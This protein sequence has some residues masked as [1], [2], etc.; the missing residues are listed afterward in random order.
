MVARIW[1]LLEKLELVSAVDAPPVAPNSATT[2]LPLPSVPCTQP[3]TPASEAAQPVVRLARIGETGAAKGRP[4]SVAAPVEE[5]LAVS[6]SRQVAVQ[7]RP[8]LVYLPPL[9]AP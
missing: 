3:L 6:C 4:V 7:S 9:L 8:T 5:P 2:L 1:L